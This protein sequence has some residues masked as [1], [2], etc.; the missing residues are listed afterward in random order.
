MVELVPMNDESHF[1]VTLDMGLETS[2]LALEFLDLAVMVPLSLGIPAPFYRP[3]ALRRPFSV[4]VL[5]SRIV[6]D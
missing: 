4:P 5:L 6:L 2:S 1:T 3:L